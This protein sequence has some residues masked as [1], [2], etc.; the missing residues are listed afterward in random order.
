MKNFLRRSDVEIQGAPVSDNENLKSLLNTTLK[1][2][3]QCSYRKDIVSLRKMKLSGTA[4]YK[5]KV[6]NPS[7]VKFRLFK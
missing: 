7:L 6:F 2:V 3:D 4:E 5:M 1:I